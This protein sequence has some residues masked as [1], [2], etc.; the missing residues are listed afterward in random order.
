MA[1]EQVALERE[2]G[3]NVD[4]KLGLDGRWSRSMPAVGSMK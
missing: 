2:L 3:R 4:Q 1:G